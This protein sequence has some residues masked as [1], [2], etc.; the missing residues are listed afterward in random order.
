MS[1][2]LTP[3]GSKILYLLRG[4]NEKRN[5]SIKKRGR[6]RDTAS[7]KHFLV[8]SVNYSR[9]NVFGGS[10]KGVCMNKDKGCYLQDYQK[11]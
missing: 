8:N 9:N 3:N 5:F 11:A 7:Y 2:T 10:F 4:R 6:L 1:M